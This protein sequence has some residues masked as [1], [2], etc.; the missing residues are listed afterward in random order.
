MSARSRTRSYRVPALLA[1]LSAVLV[2]GSVVAVAT[3]VAVAAL[4]PVGKG[5]APLVR[6]VRLQVD[7]DAEDALFEVPWITRPTDRRHDPR[8]VVPDN[9]VAPTEAPLSI[10]LV[11]GTAR[12][13]R[14]SCGEDFVRKVSLDDDRSADFAD[15]PL[16]EDCRL[17]LEGGTV[18]S[19][20]HLTAGNDYTCEVHA[21]Q[22]ICREV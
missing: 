10:A 15:V 14:L 6:G 4:A 8:V 9:V 11:G 13:V 2:G 12:S 21:P 22:L 17:T 5:G 18:A 20:R 16:D 19:T 7:H 1:L 3:I